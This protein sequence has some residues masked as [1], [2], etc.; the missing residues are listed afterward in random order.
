VRSSSPRR[1]GRGRSA[2]I[3]STPPTSALTVMAVAW[4]TERGSSGNRLRACARRSPTG[5][6]SLARASE[7]L[8]SGPRCVRHGGP[9][10]DLRGPVRTHR[11]RENF[12]ER[13]HRLHQRVGR[14]RGGQPGA[15]HAD[16]RLPR[17]RVPPLQRRRTFGTGAWTWSESAGRTSRTPSSRARSWRDMSPKSSGAPPAANARCFSAAT[18]AWAA[19]STTRSTRHC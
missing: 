1:N 4:K 18:S 17:G 10:G 3:S 9:R 6:S 15:A 2:T 7:P 13:G 5:R 12:R 19:P 8:R 16:R 11:V 14:F